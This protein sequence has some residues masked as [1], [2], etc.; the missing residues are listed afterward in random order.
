ME[1]AI[2]PNCLHK[3]VRAEK[4][5][6]LGKVIGPAFEALHNEGNFISIFLTFFNSHCVSVQVVMFPILSDDLEM[7]VGD[8][9]Q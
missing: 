1:K 7:K 5:N 6:F 3:C 4:L 2:L 9:N 8:Q